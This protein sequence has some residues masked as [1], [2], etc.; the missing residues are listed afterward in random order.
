M[1]PSTFK[2]S[3]TDLC[4]ISADSHQG[5]TKSA[6]L[7]SHCK[8]QLIYPD[9]SVKSMSYLCTWNRE[10][11]SRGRE[12]EKGSLLIQWILSQL[13]DAAL[14]SLHKHDW[15]ER[16]CPTIDPQGWGHTEMSTQ[17]QGGALPSKNMSGGSVN[18]AQV[19]LSLTPDHGT[20]RKGGR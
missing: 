8:H 19:S 2:L 3:P 5:S 15:Q 13:V 20:T 17:A 9:V 18:R 12:G 6:N 4:R 14:I 7:Y 16:Y 1:S 11:G 10:M